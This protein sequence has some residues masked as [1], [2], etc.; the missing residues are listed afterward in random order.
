MR[1]L[2]RLSIQ[3]LVQNSCHLQI[4]CHR[5]EPCWHYKSD[6]SLSFPCYICKEFVR[7]V[8]I[9]VVFHQPRKFYGHMA[10]KLLLFQ[11][12]FDKVNSHCVSIVLPLLHRECLV[13]IP[14]PDPSWGSK[15]TCKHGVLGS[16][17]QNL[18]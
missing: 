9:Q 12:L 7:R 18:L 10:Y 8:C 2:Y 4:C 13:H 6:F 1:I 17:F 11:M 5:R 16:Q 3:L 15:S 14:V